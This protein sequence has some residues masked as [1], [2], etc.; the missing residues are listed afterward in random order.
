VPS[1][2]P[3]EA[4]RG[5]IPAKFVRVVWSEQYGDRA[6]VL[7]QVNDNPPYFDLNDCV[8]EDGKW[9]CDSSGGTGEEYPDEYRAWL[10]GRE[11]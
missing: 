11:G 1:G 9:L 7:L 5:S 6:V 2:T 10:E 8:L 4:A 3:E